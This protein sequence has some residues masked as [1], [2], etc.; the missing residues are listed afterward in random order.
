MSGDF[1]KDV[2]E[3]CKLLI[4][5]GQ[6]Q[7]GEEIRLAVEAG[8][9]GSEIMMRLRK[10]F[11]DALGDPELPEEMRARITTLLEAVNR[12]I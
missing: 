1:Y 7:L 4:E 9:T 11:G 12:V 5:G 10:H 2:E 3:L 8:S 6:Q